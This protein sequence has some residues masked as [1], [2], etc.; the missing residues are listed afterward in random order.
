MERNNFW[1]IVW[2][3]KDP[4]WG[5]I[6]HFISI[7]MF[8]ADLAGSHVIMTQVWFWV[9]WHK[10]KAEYVLPHERPCVQPAPPTP[11]NWKKQTT[12]KQICYGDFISPNVTV[13]LIITMAIDISTCNTN[14]LIHLFSN[15]AV[16][17]VEIIHLKAAQTSTLTERGDWGLHRGWEQGCSLY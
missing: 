12:W 3:C 9:W 1:T 15:G 5:F 6:I 16:C 10:S 13:Y 2:F 7:F 17:W 14:V 11:H 4:I 8:F